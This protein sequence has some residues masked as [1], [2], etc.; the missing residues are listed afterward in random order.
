MNK[1][2]NK[3]MFTTS[4]LGYKS[5]EEGEEEKVPQLWNGEEM[6]IESDVSCFLWYIDLHKLDLKCNAILQ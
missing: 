4:V 6:S 2:V 1:Q 3:K 5:K